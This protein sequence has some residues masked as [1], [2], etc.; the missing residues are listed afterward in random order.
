MTTIHSNLYAAQGRSI[1]IRPT[2]CSWK[3][4]QEDILLHCGITNSS[5]EVYNFNW[6]ILKDKQWG[7]CLNVPLGL[8][9]LSDEE[10]DQM[11]HEHYIQEKKLSKI[12]PYQQLDNNCFDFVIRFLN[13]VG[14]NNKKTHTKFTMAEEIL[15]KPV[16][17]FES[18]IYIYRALEED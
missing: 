16:D 10:F 8:D 4:Y 6:K 9:H 14:Y 5:G 2:L 7:Q 18:Y 13:I 11:I 3:N 1:V 17:D 12:K 15:D